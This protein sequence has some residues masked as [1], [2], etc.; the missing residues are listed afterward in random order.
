M[1]FLGI[2]FCIGVLVCV[3]LAKS[4]ILMPSK[5]FKSFADEAL[6]SNSSRFMEL[7]DKYFSSY[8]R[9]AGNDFDV[10]GNEILK[11]VEPV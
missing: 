2:G 10:K 5:K 1:S 6:F 4:G 3:L 9:E 7:A 8:V 11:I